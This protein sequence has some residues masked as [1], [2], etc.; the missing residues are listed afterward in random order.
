MLGISPEAIQ[1]E[2]ELRLDQLTVNWHSEASKPA[3]GVVLLSLWSRTVKSHFSPTTSALCTPTG[4]AESFFRAVLCVC[5]FAPSL[6]LPRLCLLTAK[7]TR[8]L[9]DSALP[10]P[11]FDVSMQQVARRCRGPLKCTV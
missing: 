1:V 9:A 5:S 8:R 7:S 6:P 4:C 2:P 11:L 10:D 3:D